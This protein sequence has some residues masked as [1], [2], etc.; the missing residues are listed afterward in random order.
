VRAAGAISA[1]LLSASLPAFASQRA[2]W[3]P[4]SAGSVQTACVDANSEACTAALEAL[5][6]KAADD[7]TLVANTGRPEYRPMARDAARMPFAS[8]RAA[9]AAAL[10]HLSPGPEDTPLLTVLLNDAVPMVRKSA[11]RALETSSDPA[12]RPLAQR[13]RGSQPDGARPQAV[14][15][16]DQLKTPL[17]AGAQYLFFAS[18]RADGQSEFSTADAYDKVA[19]FYASKYGSG[20]TFEQFQDAAKKSKDAFPDLGSQAYQ[21]QVQAAMEAQKAYQAALK[22]G[23]S[24]QEATQVMIAAMSKNAPANP[25]KIKSALEKKDV[26]GSPRLFVVEKGM[27]PSAPARLV[28]VYKDLLLGKT[29]IAIFT[30]PLPAE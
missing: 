13:V 24:Q 16:A 21:D 30:G 22:A 10:S 9:G 29:G 3:V 8:L 12:A 2:V 14:P 25:S 18:S 17:Y 11:Q 5:A 26:Y 19:S 4:A 1:F 7:L 28:A 20:I 23:K 6:R 27:M 15:T